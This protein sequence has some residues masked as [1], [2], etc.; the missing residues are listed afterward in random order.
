MFE[1]NEVYYFANSFNAQKE[2]QIFELSTVKYGAQG[3][4]SF[5][6]LRMIIS[7]TQTR[8]NVNEE[9]LCLINNEESYRLLTNPY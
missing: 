2:T 4:D 1:T 7:S 5:R 3:R 6:D 9:P 8:I